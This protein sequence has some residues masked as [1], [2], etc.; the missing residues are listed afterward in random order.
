VSLVEREIVEREI[1][2]LRMHTINAETRPRVLLAEDNAI[3]RFALRRIV[4]AHAELIAEADDGQAA[5]ELA[6]KLKPDVVLLDISMPRLSGLDAARLI[7]TRLPNV[8][9]L[10][11]SNYSDAAHIDEAFRIGA[12]GYVLKGSAI[13]QLPQAIKD[14]L[15]G[16][17]FRS[18]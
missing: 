12:D 4:E 10:I 13:F 17:T 6:E 9:I 7:K 15:S 5:V 8:R 2:S 1:D 18:V 16:R 14:A 3:I 11:L